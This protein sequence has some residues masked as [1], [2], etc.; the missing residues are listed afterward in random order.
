MSTFN[1]P[2][3]M[4][5]YAILIVLHHLQNIDNGQIDNSSRFK[6]S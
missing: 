5:L 6:V 3:D 4:I 2:C 1:V